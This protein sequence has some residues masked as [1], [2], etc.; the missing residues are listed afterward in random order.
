MLPQLKQAFAPL[1]QR[2]QTEAA[3]TSRAAGCISSS[4]TFR[5]RLST[6]PLH[7]P[8]YCSSHSIVVRAA[9]ALGRH[10]RDDFVRIHD[11]AG[12][13][14]HAVR[15]I[16]VQLLSSRSVG[17]V[18]YLVDIRGTEVLARVAKLLRAACRTNI[19]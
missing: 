4:Q 10:P 19:R 16:Q 7:V 15:W 17:R 12:L 13:A 2:P 8:A 5:G 14:V 6:P 1:G 3:S 9:T 11:V 18:L